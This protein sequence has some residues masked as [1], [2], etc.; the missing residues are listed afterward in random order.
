MIITRY[1]KLGLLVILALLS[2]NAFAHGNHHDSVHA[3]KPKQQAKR[4][5]ALTEINSVYL[6]QVKPIF[7]KK[8]F[9]CHSSQTQFPWYHS[10]PGVSHLIDADIAEGKKHLDMTKDF[11]FQ[12]HGSPEDDLQAIGETLQKETM[13]PLSYRL[14]H[15]ESL[16]TSEEKKIMLGWIAQSLE[17]LGNG[18]KREK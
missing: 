6:K 15:W 1:R 2:A 3:S 4:E 17:V 18:E 16:P 10:I 14:M 13:P 8:C 11:P 5:A 9:D 7:L 12:G